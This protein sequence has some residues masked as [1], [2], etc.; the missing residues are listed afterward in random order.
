MRVLTSGRLTVLL[1]V[2]CLVLAVAAGVLWSRG[3]SSAAA[4]A[5]KGP[6]SS[7]SAAASALEA[8]PRLT[9]RVL[10]YDWKTLDDDV[11][12]SHL[13]STPSFSQQY[14][15]TLAPVRARARRDEV[16]V[17]AKAVASAVVSASR[18]RVVALV[19]VDQ[20]TVARGAGNQRVDQNRVLVTV[21]RDAGEWLVSTMRTF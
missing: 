18:S 11:R 2:L 7:P 16:T 3:V 1:V 20:T 8:V 5:T 4:P 10:S 21:T 15:A 14:D 12:D 19:F 6:V 13:A 17:E 9:E